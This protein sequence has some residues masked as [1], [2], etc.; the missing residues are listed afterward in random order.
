MN[1]LLNKK[2][3]VQRSNEWYSI[4]NNIITSTDVST[5]L[6]LNK[7]AQLRSRPREHCEGKLWSG[8]VD[9]AQA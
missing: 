1:K 8:I 5:I 3:I 6:D 2:Q 4:R 7:N 9:L